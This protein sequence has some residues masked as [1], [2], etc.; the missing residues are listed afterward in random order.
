MGAT[1]A[2]LEERGLVER[3]H[4]P[5]DG[6]RA[7]MTVTE[8]GRQMLQDKRTTRAAQIG[9][10]LYDNFTPAEMAT[11]MAASDLIERLGEVI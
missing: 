10:A 2:A 9:K 1:L 5:D 7:L 8:A 6:R 4:D 11:L 3:H